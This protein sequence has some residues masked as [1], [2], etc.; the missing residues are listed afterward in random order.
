MPSKPEVSFETACALTQS[1]LSGH[2]RRTI[3]ATMADAPTLDAAL[4]R[5]RETLTANAFHVDG[6]RASLDRIVKTYDRDTRAEGFHVLHDWDGKSDR[7]NENSIPVD[8][9]DYLIRQ[10]GG[11]T[12]DATIVAVLIDYYFV[13]VLELLALR[14]WDEGD[15][16]AN[17]DRIG[18]LL[19]LLQSSDGSGQT[20]A[21]S[22]E[23]L[24]LL[25]TSH[26]ELHERGYALLLERVRTLNAAHRLLIAIGHAASMGSHL[27]FG[28][29]ASYAR[30]TIFMRDDN[31]ADYPWL[32]FALLT[33]IR[34]LDSTQHPAPAPAP[35]PSTPHPA[36]GTQHPAP[37][38]QHPA[39]APSTQH[40]APS[41]QQLTESLLNGLSADARAFIG[42]P[43]ASLS[44]VG[45]ERSEFRDRFLASR[46]VL[47]VAF[48][49]FRPS[50]REY[51]PLS[52]FFNFA[53]NVRKGTVVDALLRRDPWR[54]SF[55]DLL[56]SLPHG[57]P[58]NTQKQQLATT[59]M[60]YARLNP[61]RIRGQLMPVI[62][63][64]PA[65]GRQAFGTTLR[66]LKA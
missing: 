63:Y 35:A 64:D 48:E 33:I 8:V 9:L 65:A 13:H 36:P 19:A 24:I 37:S 43:P 27:R 54:I 49:P 45:H 32:C 21:N 51:S 55:D 56:T 23:T 3:A 60:N 59:L 25:A 34:E 28:F 57:D 16:D 18:N 40:S 53:H 4:R 5:L 50:E 7:V 2:H 52:F 1:I 20:F 47:L 10:R 17:L 42:V 11:D 14:A 58:R 38:T 29:E 66:R 30:D 39:P 61:D 26:F 41:T 6:R 44:S 12:P 46:D 31:V 22:V 15:A 62:V